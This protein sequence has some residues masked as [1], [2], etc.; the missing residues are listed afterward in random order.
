MGIPEVVFI[1]NLAFPLFYW[2]LGFSLVMCFWRLPGGQPQL[3]P[4]NLML[5]DGKISEKQTQLAQ[6]LM[7][8]HSKSSLIFGTKVTIVLGASLVFRWWRIRL[9][10]QETWVWYL[11]REDS[12]AKRMATHSSILAWEIPWTEEPGGYSPWGY[13]ESTGLS[14]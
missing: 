1:C 9:P 7:E 4:L 3:P 5:V 10:M 12:L 8:C 6:Y 11:G 2:G 14:N 13:K